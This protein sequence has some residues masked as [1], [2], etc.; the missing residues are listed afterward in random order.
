MMATTGKR[1]RTGCSVCL[2]RKRKCDEEWMENGSCKRCHRGGLECIRN[3]G[4]TPAET[5]RVLPELRY[6]A[7]SKPPIKTTN[8]RGKQKESPTA[9][10]ATSPSN[11]HITT[12]AP[13]TPFQGLENSHLQ[14]A[15]PPAYQQP[16][17]QASTS[18]QPSASSISPAVDTFLPP[19]NAFEFPIP[20]SGALSEFHY[21]PTYSSRPYPSPTTSSFPPAPLNPSSTSLTDPWKF[22]DLLDVSEYGVMATSAANDVR[23]GI[24]MTLGAGMA[25]DGVCRGGED[26]GPE[27]EVYKLYLNIDPYRDPLYVHLNDLYLRSFPKKVRLQ[28]HQYYETYMSQ[29]E[30]TRTA[31]LAVA[32][33]YYARNQPN[34]SPKQKRLLIHSR[35]LFLH[36]L[37]LL[38][39]IPSLPLEIVLMATL[40][41]SYCQIESIGGAGVGGIMSIAEIFVKVRLGENY[42]LDFLQALTPQHIYLVFF[43]FYDIVRT[44]SMPVPRRPIVQVKGTPGLGIIPSPEESR[45]RGVWLKEIAS[46][47][48]SVHLG[49]PVAL[50]LCFAG[51]A[52]LAAEMDGLAQTE[53]LQRASEIEE[54]IRTWRAEI[55]YDEDESLGSYKAIVEAMTQEMWRQ[56]ALICLNYSIHKFGSMAQA[57]RRPAL[58]I[59]QLGTVT[60]RPPSEVDL[61]TS[62]SHRACP[63]FLAATCAISP[64]EREQCRL[65]LKMCGAQRGFRETLEAAEFLWA[66]VD[67]EGHTFDWRTALVGAHLYPCFI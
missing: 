38:R 18:T 17:F 44:I 37:D 33:L 10:T 45:Q 1:S 34:G 6:L 50:A 30:T 28:L 5:T 31:A 57:I 39:K 59:I 35:S 11:S 21:F 60:H 13:L 12:Q 41:L 36:A 24:E 7:S 9:A 47:P 53:I 32:L 4:K 8:S 2:T 54:A 64:Y 15:P 16:L 52:T 49:M 29:H 42:V 19:L 56:A 61:H 51:I 43:V 58:Q 65:G 3:P 40:D 46:N 62:M 25:V 22:S 66:K 26:P 20:F 67:S 48:M 63:W 27:D 55:H 14:T 23:V